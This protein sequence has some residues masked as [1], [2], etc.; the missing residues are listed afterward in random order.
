[1]KTSFGPRSGFVAIESLEN[2][3]LMSAAPLDVATGDVNG[4]GRADLV[5]LHSGF[6]QTRIGNG[7]G[8]FVNSTRINLAGPLDH[9]QINQVVVGDFN[10]D[11]L[12]DICVAGLTQRNGQTLGIIGVLIA[13]EVDPGAAPKFDNAIV[14]NTSLTD[15]TSNTILV[16]DWDGNG[17]DNIGFA[18]EQKGFIEAVYR[19]LRSTQTTLPS[20]LV[21]TTFGRGIHVATGDVN[22]D[23]V[24]DVVGL[25]RQ[26]RTHVAFG[27]FSNRKLIFDDPFFFDADGLA[28]VKTDRILLGDADHQPGME[29]FSFAGAKMYVSKLME[30]EGIFYF[31][32]STNVQTVLPAVQRNAMI[33]DVNGDGIGDLLAV[34]NGKT[35]Y[36]PAS[37][38]FF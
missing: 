15:G 6:V 5:E 14:H 19:D 30:E 25:D 18:N 16:G 2:R 9:D 33:A 31:V 3:R 17:A 35:L 29:I 10:G 7:D 23:G 4:D 28:N 24:A 21:A 13:L 27:V 12:D 1:M 38:A 11:G 37:G 32:N 26:G 36:D 22:G 8:T 20:P 34:V